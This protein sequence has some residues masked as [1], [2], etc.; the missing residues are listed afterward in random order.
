MLVQTLKGGG[1]ISLGKFTW[2]H[3]LSPAD[4]IN[5]SLKFTKHCIS[6]PWPWIVYFWRSCG[7]KREC[8]FRN[9]LS[10]DQG[11]LSSLLE[12]DFVSELHGPYLALLLG[13]IFVF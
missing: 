2:G 1:L 11:T 3:R 9:S 13:E 6:W 7:V 10:Q 12:E 5:S 8:H 4:F